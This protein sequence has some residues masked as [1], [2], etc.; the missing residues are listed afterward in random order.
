MY[1]LGI[2]FPPGFDSLS[3]YRDYIDSL[4][5]ADEPEIF[6]MHNNAN[7]AFQVSKYMCVLLC[8]QHIR[9]FLPSICMSVCLSI[10]LLLA[11]R[12][13]QLLSKLQ[14]YFPDLRSL[15]KVIR[16]QTN[17]AIVL[18]KIAHKELIFFSS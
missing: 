3:E 15:R 4:P 10:Y 8:T 17:V 11:F 7:I 6:G 13:L 9:T 14:L 2:Y 5:I 1:H 18:P 12:H 16:Q